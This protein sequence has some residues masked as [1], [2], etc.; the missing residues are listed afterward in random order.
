MRI[1]KK[2]YLK[3]IWKVLVATF[4]GFSNDNGLKLSA[5]LAYYTVFSLAPLL[6]LVISLAGLF[7]GQ[8]AATNKL[9]PQIQGYVGAQAAAQI[10]DAL[11]HLQLSGKSGMAV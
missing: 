2:E 9:Y 10:Q 6:I 11:K 3:K 4:S 5:S 1:F 7:L 8:D